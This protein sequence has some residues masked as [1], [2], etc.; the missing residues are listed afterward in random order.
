M[1]KLIIVLLLGSFV[2]VSF[3]QKKKKKGESPEKPKPSV[4]QQVYKNALKY[5][6][7][8]SAIVAIQFLL[9]EDPEGNKTYKDSLAYLYFSA[10]QFPQAIKVSEE[11]LEERPN[12]TTLLEVVAVSYQNLGDI[13]SA[14]SYYEKLYNVS[15]NLR[16]LYNVASLQYYLQRLGEAKA[17]IAK[18]ISNPE[19][20]KIPIEIVVS[21]NQKEQTNLMAASYNI[22]GILLLAQKEF[23]AA[24]EAFNLALKYDPNF[25]LP[26]GNLKL[27]EQ[28]EKQEQA[29]G[30]TKQEEN[31]K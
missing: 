3:A 2:S 20:A 21:Q 15:K 30:N 8:N 22:L 29:Q 18:I 14:L 1:K 12:D 11:I 4:Y 27:L 26:K 7:F 16:D 5:N 9:A 25:S 13:K 23:K 17:S 31:K 19:A 10:G 24:K 28:A 6:D